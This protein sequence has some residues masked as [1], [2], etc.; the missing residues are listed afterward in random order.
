[1]T[2][3]HAYYY[4]HIDSKHRRIGDKRNDFRVFIPQTLTNCSRV[5]LKSFSIENTFSNLIG[6]YS[7]DRK[8]VV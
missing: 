1:M 4:L 7:V 8:S 5:A 2:E 6:N 3:K